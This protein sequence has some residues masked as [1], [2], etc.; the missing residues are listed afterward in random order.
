MS[1]LILRLRQFRGGNRTPREAAD[2]IE[3]LE[4]AVRQIG[5]M[6]LLSDENVNRMTLISATTWS[7]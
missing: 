1:D 6:K 5:R 2:R 7:P 4:A 3:A